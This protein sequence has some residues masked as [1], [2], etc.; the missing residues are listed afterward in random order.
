M[1]LD[2]VTL[3]IFCSVILSAATVAAQ[4]APKPAAQ[5]SPPATAPAP[6]RTTA[7]F[8]DWVLRCDRRPD[9]T[10]PQRFCELQETIQKPGD[11]G[12]QAQIALGRILATDPI[13]MTA[14]LPINVS[15]QISPKI[16][17]DGRDG[18]T[19]ELPWVRCLPNGCFANAIVAD[20]VLRKLR[21][22]K[23][24]GRLE[25]RDGADRNVVVPV[26]FRGFSEAWEAFV[27]ESSN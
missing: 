25:Y 1:T 10:P 3:G 23:D 14:L 12:P 17:A 8:G 22:Q 24:A 19:I 6:D 20:D 11:P 7:S 4:T 27:R 18:Q 16:V 2:R 9:V 5:A 13:R 15:L 21:S 26:S